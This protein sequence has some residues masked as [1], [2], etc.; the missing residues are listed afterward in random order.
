M[1][2]RFLPSSKQMDNIHKEKKQP[3]VLKE[4]LDGNEVTERE[5]RTLTYCFATYVVT[6]EVQERLATEIKKCQKEYLIER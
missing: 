2:N 5:E 3:D 1:Q 6:K 4:L